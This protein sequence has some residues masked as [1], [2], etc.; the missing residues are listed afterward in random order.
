VRNQGMCGACWA[1]A[2]AGSV[3]G[4]V[5]IRTGRMVAVSAQ[6]LLD[7]D[8]RFNKGCAGGSPFY[9]F[10][11][12]AEK[13]ITSWDKYPYVPQQGTCRRDGMPGVSAIH[14]FG[15]VPPY[16]QKMLMAAVAEAPVT[17]GV[18]GTQQS[19]LFYQAGVLDDPQCCTQQNHAL[20]IV[21]WG[22]DEALGPYWLAKNSWSAQWGEQGYIR[23]RRLTGAMASAR[24][25][26]QCG[27][28]VSPSLALEGFG[29]NATNDL[30]P[31][32]PNP[33][34]AWVSGN[35]RNLL[36]ALTGL[37]LVYWL[38]SLLHTLCAPSWRAASAG[39][40]GAQAPPP[41]AGTGGGGRY[42]SV[43]MVPVQ[44]QAPPR[45]QPFQGRGRRLRDPAEGDGLLSHA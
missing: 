25:P 38:V 40:G 12:I 41:P 20:L 8:T 39:W 18:C 3:E 29:G 27:L 24:S 4:S 21:G 9:A 30:E 35:W 42:G 2:A 11:Y 26:G 1:F 37:V 22:D 44:A 5:A 23:L 45:V 7:C 13:G 15:V 14:E 32:P 28:A 10:Q 16:N 36:L 31:P 19:F 43:A 6:E 33:L 17:A 34:L